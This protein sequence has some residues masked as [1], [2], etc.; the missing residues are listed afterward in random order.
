M[1]RLPSVGPVSVSI[2]RVIYS[3]RVSRIRCKEAKMGRGGTGDETRVKR[4]SLFT[5]ATLQKDPSSIPSTHNRQLTAP[6]PRD[7]TSSSGL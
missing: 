3:T 5:L 4:T 2:G 6:V 1:G 7:L